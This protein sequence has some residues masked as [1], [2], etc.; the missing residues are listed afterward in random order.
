MIKKIAALSALALSA[1]TSTGGNPADG[2]WDFSMSSP[3]GAV[4]AIVTMQA[5]G[6]VLTGEFDLGNGR[7]WPIEDG[8]IAGDAIAFTINRDGASMSYAMS[9]EISGDSISGNAAA[10]GTT[11]GWSMTRAE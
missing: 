6:G 3:M 9:A 5:D 2:T 4:D 1:C 8:T 7:T 11:V 10:M